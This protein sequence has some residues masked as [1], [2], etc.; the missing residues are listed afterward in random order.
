MELLKKIKQATELLI[1]VA[2]L[3]VLLTIPLSALFFVLTFYF[4]GLT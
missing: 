2:L 3:L 1:P 4:R